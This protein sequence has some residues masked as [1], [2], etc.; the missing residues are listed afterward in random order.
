MCG[1]VLNTVSEF[2][3]NAKRPR[4]SYFSFC[5]SELFHDGGPYHKETSPLIFSANQWTG[6]YKI[7]TPSLKS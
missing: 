6:F 2:L 3:T 5:F 1:T 4:V 7:G